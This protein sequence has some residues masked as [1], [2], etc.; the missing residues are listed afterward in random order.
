MGRRLKG[1]SRRERSHAAFSGIQ[2]KSGGFPL[3][4][5]AQRRNSRRSRSRC[6]LTLPVDVPLTSEDICLVISCHIQQQHPDPGIARWE[7]LYLMS[8]RATYCT[9]N[10]RTAAIACRVHVDAIAH[11]QTCQFQVGTCA[12]YSLSNLPVYKQVPWIWSNLNVISR[13]AG[14]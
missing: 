13:N 2:G 3:V 12:S 7:N 4:R 11:I 9:T 6:T 10:G 8:S 1:G 14:I 5:C